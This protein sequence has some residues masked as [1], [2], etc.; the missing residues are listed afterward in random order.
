[1]AGVKTS[2]GVLG[3]VTSNLQLIRIAMSVAVA[4]GIAGACD[5]AS[6]SA[7]KMNL[8][9]HLRTASDVIFLL[10]TILL[11]VQIALT[12]RDEKQSKSSHH[13]DSH[14]DL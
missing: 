1:M 13:A 4:L 5:S 3:Q 8:G 2:Y 6:A 9:K 11:V 12:F 7:S 10:L 14:N